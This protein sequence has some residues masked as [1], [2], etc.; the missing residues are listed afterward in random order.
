MENLNKIQEKIYSEFGIKTRVGQKRRIWL[1]TGSG[2][3]LD[4]LRFLKELGF[5]HLSSVSALDRP[6]QERLELVYHLWS[7]Q[8]KLLLSVKTKIER[9]APS[10]DSASSIW[11]S[12]QIQE[13]EI[14][15]LF[16][17]NFLGNP[18]LTEL[19][20]EN[21]QGPPPFLKDFDWREYV[22]EK[23]YSKENKN[24]KGYFE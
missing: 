3:L 15:E 18:D 20:L 5:E 4:L 19:F 23:Y 14:H 9:K 10:I 12:A 11:A 8:D 6:E 16:G 22:K 24:E 2:Q 1:K 13:R 21:W 7:Y 17:V